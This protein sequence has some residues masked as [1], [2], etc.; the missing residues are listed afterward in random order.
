MITGESSL[1]SKNPGKS[2]IAGSVNYSGSFVARVTRVPG[3]N[4]ISI[5]GT[6]VDEVKSS[7]PDIQDLADRVASFFAPAVLGLSAIVFIAWV[8]VEQ[9]VRHQNAAAASIKAMTFSISVLIVS[10]PCAIGLAVPMVVVIA[11]GVAARHGLIFKTANTIDLA[12]NITHVIFDKTGTLTQGSL[13][14]TKEEYPVGNRDSMMSM[15]LSL[16]AQSKHPVSKA[17]ASH[18]YSL[19]TKSSTICNLKSIPGSGVEASWNG[20][21]VRAGNPYWLSIKDIPEVQRLL[22]LGLTI[23]CVTLD[24]ELVALF[25]L[26][27]LLRQDAID[28]ITELKKRSIDI[29]I[30]SGDNEKTVATIAEELGISISNTRACYSPQEKQAYVK[31]LLEPDTV[32]DHSQ[33][34][35]SHHH[36]RTHHH[37]HFQKPVVLFVGDGSNDAPSLA[38][39][40]IGLHISDD[41]A[42][43]TVASS[44]SDIVLLSPSLSKILILIDLSKAFHRRVVFNFT[45]SAIYNLIAILLAAGIIP[46]ARIPPGYAGL[47]EAVSILPVLG[48]AVSLRF[49]KR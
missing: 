44:A 4:T 3:E 46:R 31:S 12:R 2:V 20:I 15:V 7:K 34:N 11:G 17:I 24:D 29:S 36:H 16:T 1:V 10:C 45:W 42:S 40:S 25:G 8:I 5:I 22:H 48:V 38:M 28:T 13:Y 21:Q 23:F 27:D 35:H 26:Q 49:W 33:C 39:A 19:G 30:L 32:H 43:P 18:L 37:S 47:G 6:L 9:V 41:S 14:V